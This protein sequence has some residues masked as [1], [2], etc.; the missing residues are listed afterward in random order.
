MPKKVLPSVSLN[1]MQQL[2]GDSDEDDM[3]LGVLFDLGDPEP[4]PEA[5]EVSAPAP[6]VCRRP[7][8][9]FCVMRAVSS[10]SVS[11]CL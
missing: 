7:V 10:L 11:S 2:K 6:P 1:T 5:S 4:E 3:S 8:H 9:L